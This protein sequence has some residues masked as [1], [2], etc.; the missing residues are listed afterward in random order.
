[1]DDQGAA[2]A[3]AD[4]LGGRLERP[5]RPKAMPAA[6]P[7]SE[8]SGG[9][10]V[11]RRNC[12]RKGSSWSAFPSRLSKKACSASPG[13]L[14]RWETRGAAIASGRLAPGPG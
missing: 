13:S 10:G 5:W 2:A 11:A 4:R 14:L 1:V 7:I 12:S 8:G 3:A 9:V 6:A